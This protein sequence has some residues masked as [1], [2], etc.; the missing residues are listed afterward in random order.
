MNRRTAF[1]DCLLTDLGFLRIPLAVRYI[2]RDL[3]TAPGVAL[4]SPLSSADRRDTQG[5]LPLA[6]NPERNWWHRHTS[7]KLYLFILLQ[8]KALWITL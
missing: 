4:L 6:S 7:I 2:P 1:I 5:N 8:P 3:C